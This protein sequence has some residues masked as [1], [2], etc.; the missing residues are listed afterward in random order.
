MPSFE[1][2]VDQVDV[3]TNAPRRDQTWQTSHACGTILNWDNVE[4]YVDRITWCSQCLEDH[5]DGHWVCPKCLKEVNPRMVGPSGIR[6]TIP[7]MVHYLID[8]VEVPP[9]EWHRQL[10]ETHENR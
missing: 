8:G 6:E 4:W 1:K 2:V 5:E 7:G 3:T 9:L 10:K